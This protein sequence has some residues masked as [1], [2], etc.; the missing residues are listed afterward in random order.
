LLPLSILSEN[1]Q[2]VLVTVN[3]PAPDGDEIQPRF[4]LSGAGVATVTT[5]IG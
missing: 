4:Q 1:K 2:S 3:M 5:K